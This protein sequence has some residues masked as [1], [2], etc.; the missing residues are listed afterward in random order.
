M[1][2]IN[3]LTE[4]YKSMAKHNRKKADNTE[5]E[6]LRRAFSWSKTVEGFDFWDK[7]N[8]GKQPKISAHIESSYPPEVFN[9]SIAHLSQQGEQ[10]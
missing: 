3:N 5:F 1:I 7:V 10:C 2:E 6:N 8:N 4:P 9:P